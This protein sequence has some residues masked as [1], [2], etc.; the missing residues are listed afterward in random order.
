MK[1][2]RRSSIQRST[3][4]G[5]KPERRELREQEYRYAEHEDSCAIAGKSF[6][7]DDRVQVT[8]RNRFSSS[9]RVRTSIFLSQT[10]DEGVGPKRVKIG[11][12]DFWRKQKELVVEMQ[13]TSSRSLQ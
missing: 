8:Q 2:T 9:S 3:Q 1:T 10:E 11:D 5:P 4:I 13:D 12:K 7:H 6:F